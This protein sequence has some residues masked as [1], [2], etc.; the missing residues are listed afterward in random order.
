MEKRRDRKNELRREQKTKSRKDA[1]CIEYI[2]LKYGKIYDEVNEMYTKLNAKYPNKYDL[3]KTMEIK[4]MES[5]CQISESQFQD[6]PK[7]CRLKFGKHF[8]LKDNVSLRI[9]LMSHPKTSKTEVEQQNSEIT[10]K[11]IT[12]KQITQKQ[13]GDIV[14]E[15]VQEGIAFPE[16]PLETVSPTLFDELD[17]KL[18]EEI[19]D[20]LQEDIDLNSILDSIEYDMDMH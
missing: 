5:E 18:L 7:P 2:R 20:E 13:R 12:E 17:S 6:P 10:E 8:I 11:Q 9:P 3:R 14:T 15:V 19:I 4:N 1:V 16:I